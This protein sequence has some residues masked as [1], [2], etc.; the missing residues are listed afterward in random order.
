MKI[1]KRLNH[2]DVVMKDAIFGWDIFKC[3][4]YSAIDRTGELA[5]VPIGYAII[6]AIN[7]GKFRL[8]KRSF[9]KITKN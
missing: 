4:D 9:I 2:Q 5:P 3:G 8:F 6:L 7:I 1:I